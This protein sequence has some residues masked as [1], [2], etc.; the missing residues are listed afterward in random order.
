MPMPN[1]VTA[2]K[3]R[4]GGPLGTHQ[5]TSSRDRLPSPHDLDELALAPKRN[6]ESRTDDRPGALGRATAT[7]AEMH[8][9]GG[10]QT[11]VEALGRLMSREGEVE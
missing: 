10:G 11:T 7:E 1:R 5:D 8:D 2:E 9:R 4:H 3:H 6:P